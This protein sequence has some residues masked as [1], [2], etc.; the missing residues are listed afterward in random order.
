MSVAGGKTMNM[1][2]RWDDSEGKI[3]N[4]RSRTWPTAISTT[5]NPTWVSTA[6]NRSLRGAV[7][8]LNYFKFSKCS[9]VVLG[10]QC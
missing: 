8:I 6:S 5:T 7:I 3:K 9:L 2:R 1:E 10:L 4:T